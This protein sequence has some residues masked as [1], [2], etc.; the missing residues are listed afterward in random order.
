MYEKAE[1]YY[2]YVVNNKL[3][4][5]N[6]GASPTVGKSG[7]VFRAA[8]LRRGSYWR[9]WT[10]LGQNLEL[11]LCLF[12]YK[13]FN[14]TNSLANGRDIS[15]KLSVG[16]VTMGSLN[17]VGTGYQNGNKTANLSFTYRYRENP[18][19][20]IVLYLDGIT[21]NTSGFYLANSNFESTTGE[22]TYR[23]KIL[24]YGINSNG[25]RNICRF[26][27]I[28]KYPYL[29]IPYYGASTSTSFIPNAVLGIESI[30]S[31]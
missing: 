14:F 21:T 7:I 12:E 23:E 31:R 22:S 2:Q 6:T 19:G 15:S 8:A 17:E 9:Q 4:S 24:T 26:C 5:Y 3:S 29:F 1:H 20:N 16:L 11:L 13:T 30:S 28:H 10:F 27:Y 25:N 18:Y